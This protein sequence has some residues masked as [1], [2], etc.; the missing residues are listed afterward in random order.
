M[1][2]R[3]VA[4]AKSPES[5]PFT[6]PV[7]TAAEETMA[8]WLDGIPPVENKKNKLNSRVL[9]LWRITFNIWTITTADR[10]LRIISYP[11]LSINFNSSI[12]I[13]KF[14]FYI[15]KIQGNNR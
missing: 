4:K 10:A 15:E 5:K 14:Y 9:K 7:V 11:V 8:L 12:T 13:P 6:N 3:I 2:A 1:T